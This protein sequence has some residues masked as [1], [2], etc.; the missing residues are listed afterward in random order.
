MDKPDLGYA[1][2]INNVLSEYPQSSK[3]VDA[4]RSAYQ[5]VGFKVIVHTD[6]NEKVNFKISYYM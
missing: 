6:C 1:L 3:D 5:R 2:I 4:L